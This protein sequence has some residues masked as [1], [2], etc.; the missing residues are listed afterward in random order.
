MTLTSSG[1]RIGVGM[2]GVKLNLSCNY[3]KVCDYV[4]RLLGQE[5]GPV[6]KNPDIE[7]SGSWRTDEQALPD[8]S[9]PFGAPP[10]VDAFGKHMKLSTDE[11]VWFDVHRDK[12]LQLR[13]RRSSRTFTFDVDYVYRPSEKK[14]ARYPDY[15]QRKFFSLLRYLLYFPIGWFLQRTRGW[16]LMHASAVAAEDRAILIAGP[17]GVGKTTTCLALVG[18]AGMT[19]VA[20][21][22]LF[23][24]GDEIHPLPE[25]I[26]LTDESL[27]L[28]GDGPIELEDVSALLGSRKHKSL[29][30]LPMSSEAPVVRPAAIF[31]PQ[32]SEHGSVRP[33][34]A[35]IASELLNATNRLTLELNDYNAYTAA[36]DLL[37][38][39][40]GNAQRQ[41]QV[42][43]RMTGSTPCYALGI[44]RAAGVRSVVEQINECLGWSS[45]AANRVGC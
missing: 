34:P 38:P 26:R 28:L 41:I 13:F 19:F 4:V 16:H 29:F 22:L 12:E 14:L 20:E 11:L 18:L 40:A 24:D 3:D 33:I 43:D 44:N 27:R 25:P 35:A 15:E 10:T 31:I 42:L 17:G 36:L 39:Q 45:A 32:F 21:N 1:Q 7:V 6:W 23:I 5:V 9:G 8:A 37:W 2:H 30:R